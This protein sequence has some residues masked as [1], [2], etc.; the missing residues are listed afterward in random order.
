MWLAPGTELWRLIIGVFARRRVSPRLVGL[1]LLAPVP[2]RAASLC[3]PLCGVK[4]ALAPSGKRPLDA[5]GG[6]V[7]RSRDCEVMKTR[8]AWP[9]TLTASG[10]HRS[11]QWDESDVLEMEMARSLNRNE[12]RGRI[13]MLLSFL[14]AISGIS[15]AALSR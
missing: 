14:R 4:V 7:G 9:P 8:L 12:T 10:Q 2:S 3:D 11:T 1:T 13:R 6:G 5:V 15:W